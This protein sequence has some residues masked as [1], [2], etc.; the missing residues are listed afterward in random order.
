[1]N[2]LREL[3]S[4]NKVRYK[5]DNFNLYLSYITPNIIAIAMPFSGF[6]SLY[7]NK[8]QD[9]SKLIKQNNKSEYLIINASKIEY[10]YSPFD[11]KVLTMN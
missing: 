2:F 11:N 3:V 8:I 10:D 1:M 4:N 7:R 6:S 5:D 9:V